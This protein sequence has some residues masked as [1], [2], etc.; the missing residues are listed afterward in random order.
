MLSSIKP[1]FTPP[2]FAYIKALG[3]DLVTSGKTLITPLATSGCCS[4]T[5][6][7]VIRIAKLAFALIKLLVYTIIYLVYIALYT[8]LRTLPYYI[9]VWPAGKIVEYLLPSVTVDMGAAQAIKA[10]ADL[11]VKEVKTS[12]DKTLALFYNNFPTTDQQKAI[13]EFLFTAR[14]AVEGGTGALYKAANTLKDSIQPILNGTCVLTFIAFALRGPGVRQLLDSMLGSK[15]SQETMSAAALL[16]GVVIPQLI[17]ELMKRAAVDTANAP[18]E[19]GLDGFISGFAAYTEADEDKIRGFVS[20]KNWKG[21]IDYLLLNVK[22]EGVANPSRFTLLDEEKVAIN[23]LLAQYPAASA[24]TAPDKA[25]CQLI[26]E[27]WKDLAKQMPPF[28]FIEHL[29]TDEIFPIITRFYT[30]DDILKR[31][32]YQPGAM[33]MVSSALS[34]Y[35]NFYLRN[36]LIELLPKLI[37]N[38]SKIAQSRDTFIETLKNSH[39]FTDEK[40]HAL[41][42]RIQAM[43]WSTAEGRNLFPLIEDI[44]KIKIELLKKAADDAE[45]VRK[46]D[47]EKKTKPYLSRR[48]STHSTSGHSVYT[49]AE[50]GLTPPKTPDGNETDREDE[51]SDDDGDPAKSLRPARD[52]SGTPHPSK[53]PGSMSEAEEEIEKNV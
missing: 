46:A 49:D 53:V 22:P 40:T 12:D 3:S 47:E 23:T 50:T 2:T 35:N 38:G 52:A 44:F 30:P 24:K 19:N 9:F 20:P 45:A 13:V 51:F 17:A 29:L 25:G 26:A 31:T 16:K 27:A 28:A 41:I 5:K 6:E 48:G 11:D 21:L 15:T 7:I 4:R 43:D 8:L 10:R 32:A 14:N 42:A 1:Y 18:P 37:E 34:G 33:E 36:A 39:G